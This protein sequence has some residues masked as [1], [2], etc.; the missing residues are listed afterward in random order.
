MGLNIAIIGAGI[1]GLAAAY[2]LDP[3]H[4]VTVFEA[5]DYPG[6]HTNT[7]T[8]EVQ[9]ETQRID[10]GFIV[11]NNRTYPNFSGLMDELGVLY[12]PTTMSF[13]VRDD[14]TGLEYNGHSLN[15]LFAQRRNL[16][17]PSFH[18]MLFDIARF[19][20]QASALDEIGGHDV[21]VAEFL[22]RH[23][24]SHQFAEQYLLPMGAAIW[25]CPMAKFA[26]FPIR[27]IAEFYKH[28]GLLQIRDRPTWQV[29]EGGSQTYVQRLI[30]GFQKQ[31]R[32]N[33][34]VASVRRFSDRVEVET[35]SRDKQSFD[36]VIFACHSDQA[37]RILSTL[38]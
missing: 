3:E 27:F 9:G 19:N 11:F 10:T 21:T 38:R 12:R 36:R 8:V 32:L 37:L 6:G 7:V 20:R 17:R 33:T 22:R 34:E 5:G 4:R 31:I 16:L 23:R 29:I 24:Y 35:A 14:R 15:S 28:H 26:D 1:S 13:S 30:C 25:S 18:R 2:W